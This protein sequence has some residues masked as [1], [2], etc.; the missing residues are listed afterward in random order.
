ME[1]KEYWDIVRRRAWIVV[2]LTVLAFAGSWIAS[3]GLAASYQASLRLAVKPQTEQHSST[4]Y[5]YDEYY[6]YVA[7]EYLVDDIIEVIQSQAFKDDLLDR[8]HGKV[9]SLPDKAIEGKKSHRVLVVNV[10]AGS[11]DAAQLVAETVAQVLTAPGNKYFKD[12]TSQNPVVTLVD[13]PRTVQVGESRKFLDIALRT[14]LGLIAGIALVFLLDYL[15][16]S[17]TE[18]QQ[19]ERLV[20]LPV[21]GEIPRQRKALLRR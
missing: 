20:G 2:G 4:F 8:L 9:T 13:A 14:M 17:V 16:G 15:D 7:S 19:A 12:L 10:T 3:A 6:S 18:A 11:R 21:L 1:I 5:T